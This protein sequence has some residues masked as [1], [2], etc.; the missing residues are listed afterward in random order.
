MIEDKIF[1]LIVFGL[2]LIF[3]THLIHQISIDKLQLLPFV[4][5]P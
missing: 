2:N 5:S 4:C 3:F 1:P